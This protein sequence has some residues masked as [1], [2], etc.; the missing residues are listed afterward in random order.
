VK[1]LGGTYWVGLWWEK[2]CSVTGWP[3]LNMSAHS[4]DRFPS[5]FEFKNGTVHFSKHR[6]LL[7]IL[8]DVLK[9]CTILKSFLR[10][11][12]IWIFA[13]LGCWA[14]SIAITYRRFVRMWFH[15]QMSCNLE[16]SVNISERCV[17]SEKSEDLIYTADEAWSHAE[18]FLDH[19]HPDV[20]L[21]KA[22]SKV[23]STSNTWTFID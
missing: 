21:V 20:L 11:T 3:M 6:V 10:R 17:T 7:G 19:W 4:T 1:I 16:T 9:I 12:I 2:P 22:E 18:L 23:N 14:T 8:N 5:D 13:L 15:R